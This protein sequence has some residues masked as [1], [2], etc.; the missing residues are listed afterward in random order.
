MEM[1][2]I[3]QSSGAVDQTRDPSI[4]GERFIHS[5]MAASIKHYSKVC[6]FLYVSLNTGFI[7]MID[8]DKEALFNI[9]YLKQTT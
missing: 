6:V 9:A 5:T 4:H 1:G 7:K 2:L 8:K 3:R